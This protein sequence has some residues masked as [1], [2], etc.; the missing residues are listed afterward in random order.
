[1]IQTA[2]MGFGLIAERSWWSCVP[3]APNLGSTGTYAREKRTAGNTPRRAIEDP[4][5]KQQ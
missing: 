1:M 5:I 4:Y 2:A 3:G